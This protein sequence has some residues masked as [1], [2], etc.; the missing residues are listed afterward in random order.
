MWIWQQENWPAFSWDRQRIEPLLRATRFLQGKLYGSSMLLDEANST[1]DNVLANI[2]YSSDIEGERVNAHSVRSSLAH[3]LGIEDGMT[4]AVDKKTEGLV[5]SALDA[6]EN[7]DQ[8]LSLERLLHW[9]AL[10]FPAGSGLLYPIVGGQLRS[11]PVQVVSGRLEKPVVHFEGPDSASIADDVDAF[12]QWFNDSRNDPELDPL[13]RAGIAHLRFLTLHPFEDGNGR[14]GR[15]I[16]DLALAQAESNTV[17]LY[18][19]S[20][21]INIHRQDYYQVLEN[22]QRG[23]LDITAW[24]SWFIDMLRASIEETLA[25]IDK[26]VFKTRYWQQ[27]DAAQIGAEQ[28]KVLNRLLDGDFSDGIN[29][30]QY[31]AV[32][33][34]SRATA[35]R[36]LAQLVELGY[37]LACPGGGR[38]A[39]YGLNR[40]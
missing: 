7:L 12:L 27:F 10:L 17:R 31:K 2:L 23:E 6:I 28:I 24:L 33:K 8:P 20:R 4:Y 1:L 38:S 22:T 3:H 9:H 5:A 15:L 11:G 25:V 32:A 14:I 19:M 16:M 35:T 30:S 37:L 36:H 13:L 26:T 18:A 39:R 29:N 34:V 21:T 40:L